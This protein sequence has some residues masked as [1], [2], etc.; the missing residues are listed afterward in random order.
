MYFLLKVIELEVA[1]SVARSSKL[2]VM[3]PNSISVWVS[4]NPNSLEFLIN[5]DTLNAVRI[6]N[7]F[8][9]SLPP[10]NRRTRM[11]FFR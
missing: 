1:F 3:L 7:S 9:A 4:T 5:L 10:D 6:Q 8:F 2:T 11:F